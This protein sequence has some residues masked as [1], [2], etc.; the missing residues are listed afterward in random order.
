[1]RELSNHAAELWALRSLGTE[2]IAGGTHN[3]HGTQ[4]GTSWLTEHL[5]DDYS[6]CW[7]NP[8]SNGEFDSAICD[9]GVSRWYRLFHNDCNHHCRLPLRI[10]DWRHS[11][12][13]IKPDSS[14]DASGPTFISKAST[15]RPAGR[16]TSTG[17]IVRP[18]ATLLALGMADVVLLADDGILFPRD[19]MLRIRRVLSANKGDQGLID[20]HSSNFSQGGPALSYMM[21]VS[22]ATLWPVQALKTRC[23]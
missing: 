22:T 6:K 15:Y 10:R 2:I 16:L 3:N 7:Q 8:L 19:T 1:M 20:L 12:A 17:S 23:C 11:G 4:P 14:T 18:H 13:V 21:C 9:T 5:E